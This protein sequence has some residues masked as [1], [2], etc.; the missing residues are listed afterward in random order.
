MAIVG[1]ISPFKSKKSPMKGLDP[2]TGLQIAGAVAGI[3]GGIGASRRARK[4]QA[5]AKK[6]LEEARKAYLEMEFINPYEGIENPYAGLENVYED[7]RVDTQAADYMREQTA[8]QQANLMQQYRGVAGGSGV[9]GLAQSLANVGAQ[10]ARKTSI[11][12]AQQERANQQARLGQA[13][14]LD[15]LER[16]GE[17]QTNLLRRKGDMLVKQQ[18]QARQQSLYGLALDQTTAANQARAM[19]QQQIFGGVAKGVMAGFS[20]YGPGGAGAGQFGEDFGNLRTGIENIS[21]GNPWNYQSNIPLGDK[22]YGPFL[23][24]EGPFKV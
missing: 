17:F 10:Q 2:V 5:E 20:Y 7:A 22:M 3:F 18:E 24:F 1:L 12:I 23:P 16:Q 4:E 8:Q 14:R 9:A 15:Q 19:A 6:R 21:Q 13:A 11:T